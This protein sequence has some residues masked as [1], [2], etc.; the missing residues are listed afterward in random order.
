MTLKEKF[1]PFVDWND[2]QD[3][4]TNR[5]WAIRNAE[6]CEKIAD[7]YAIEFLLYLSDWHN[8]KRAKELL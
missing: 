1:L 3:D 2:L 6:K 5:E 7:D 8:K 4:C